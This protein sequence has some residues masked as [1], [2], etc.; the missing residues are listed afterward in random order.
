M[1]RCPTCYTQ[2]PDET[3]V[4]CL[5]DGT[6][7]IYAGGADTPTVVLGE[8]ETHIRKDLPTPISGSHR[9]PIIAA[10]IGAV[11][12]LL[13]IGIVG[14]GGYLFFRN[15][16]A[17]IDHAA[18]NNSHAN[19]DPEATQKP[20]ATA[21]RT[22]VANV[23][24]TVPEIERSEIAGEITKAINARDA[25]VEARDI[26]SLR[27]QYASRMDYYYNWRNISLDK[28]VAD[29]QKALSKFTSIEVSTSNISV[30]ADSSGEAATAVYDKE[31]TFSG[32][33]KPFC[34][35][36]RSQLLFRR[37]NGKWL[38]AGEKDVPRTFRRTC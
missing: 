2:Y 25:A 5:Q 22:P 38:I 32:D 21:V 15:R 17:N 19:R 31:W 29:K 34:G 4:Y 3:L 24:P 8:T 9:S 11:L 37:V 1:K 30:S 12:M 14:I 10:A 36:V 35:R 26:D 20:S 23:K 33:E 27:K 13:L 6:P 7:L 28:V 18:V 16:A